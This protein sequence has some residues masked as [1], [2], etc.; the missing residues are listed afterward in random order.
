MIEAVKTRLA[1]CQ[2]VTTVATLFVVAV[3]TAGRGVTASA[4]SE[5]GKTRTPGE[6][7]DPLTDTPEALKSYTTKFNV[8]PGWHF[9]TGSKADINL[10]LW[11]SLRI[12]RRT[13]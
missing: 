8:K 4:Q 3:T 7:A 1:S 11:Q 13:P 12:L 5:A 2:R 9:L 6:V 10:L